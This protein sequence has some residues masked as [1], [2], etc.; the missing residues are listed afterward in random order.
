MS[1]QDVTIIWGGG[2]GGGGG[3]GV[4]FFLHFLKLSGGKR[5][6]LAASSY[7]MVIEASWT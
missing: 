6:W 4:C 1:L 7:P 2:G 5:D 3:G